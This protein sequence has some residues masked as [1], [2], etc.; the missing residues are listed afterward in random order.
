PDSGVHSAADWTLRQ[1]GEAL[2]ELAEK[3]SLEP[4]P[5]RNWWPHELGFTML[6]IPSGSFEQEDEDVS[7]R[8]RRTV[9]LSEFW[10]SDRE[11]T[12]G[13]Y[14]R[15]LDDLSEHKK[16]ID[17]EA[18]NSKVSP[19]PD[20]PMQ[21]VSWE[22][23]VLFC[24]WLSR[25]EG[26][27]PCYQLVRRAPRQK[28]AKEDEYFSEPNFDVTFDSQ[29]DGYRLPTEAEW[30]YACR[31]RS[32]TAYSFGDGDTWLKRYG[33]S[34]SNTKGK[35]FAVRALASNRWG[36]FDMHGNVWEWCQ[37]RYGRYGK[38][39]QQDPSGP[40]EGRGRV[41]R[42]GSWFNDSVICS[43]WFRYYDP[44]G[45]RDINIGFRLAR[46]LPPDP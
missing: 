5:N 35:S 1:W 19:T 9:Q 38:K 30:E 6:R 29:S 31:A 37:D 44:P 32:S 24:N 26:R 13:L 40:A 4:P 27:K 22:D 23:A 45:N 12:V 33:V 18:A 16:P 36:S 10:L 7:P 15:F 34:A 21:N 11:V 46:T 43:A 8:T 42:G 17:P 39:P 28:T 25:R 41:L 3:P 14:Q 20:H 2:P